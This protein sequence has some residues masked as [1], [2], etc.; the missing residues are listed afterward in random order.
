[1]GLWVCG[2]G[3]PFPKI[4]RALVLF[5]LLAMYYPFVAIA[6]GVGLGLSAKHG[7]TILGRTAKTHQY[8][9]FYLDMVTRALNNEMVGNKEEVS[10]VAGTKEI[11]DPKVV[12][13]ACQLQKK[14][15]KMLWNGQKLCI[16]K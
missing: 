3:V 13:R 2:Y 6:S 7:W 14:V 5:T 4:G 16:K 12:D 11:K 9:K 8:A 15:I 1:M 10:I